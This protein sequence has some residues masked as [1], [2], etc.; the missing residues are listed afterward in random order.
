M[1]KKVIV[2]NFK[3]FGYQEFDLPSWVVISGPNNSGK[4]S[5]LQAIS[6]WCELALHWRTENPDLSRGDDGNYLSKEL[7]LLRFHSVLLEDFDHLWQYKNTR[8]PISIH[9]EISS[10][11]NRSIGFEI[12][13]S[14]REIAQVRPTKDANEDDL[15]A[16]GR[17]PMI[18]TYIPPVSGLERQ[19]DFYNN[20][21]VIL[22]R[23]AHA[24]GGTVLRNLISK[25]RED[26]NNWSLLKEEVYSHFGYEIMEPSSGAQVYIRYRHHDTDQQYDLSNAASGFLQILLVFAALLHRRASVVLLDEPDAHLHMLLQRKMYE[27]LKKIASK[28][29]SQLIIA[30]HSQE[31]I[32]VADTEELRVL[33]HEDGLRSIKEKHLRDILKFDNA[34]IIKAQTGKKVLYV[35]G[36]T[37]IGILIEWAKLLRHRMFRFL[38]QGLVLKTAEQKWT[39]IKHFQSL[40]SLV[41]SLL[42]A[43]LVD[44]DSQQ[45]HA[46]L[47]RT[48]DGL[49]R[50][51]WDR[52]ELENYLIHPDAICRY[53][54]TIAGDAVQRKI[55]DFLHEELPQ[56]LLAQPFKLGVPADP[57]GKAFLAQ[58]ME[59]AG[60]QRESSYTALAGM[61]KLNEIHPEV[62]EKLDAIADQL[63]I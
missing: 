1:I 33:T 11:S 32:N 15:E 14:Q 7:N 5:L 24:Q 26:E 27:S 10:L 2:K 63:D 22:Q 8:E 30:T 28:S 25:V 55:G 61:M 53:V 19:E 6:A 42:G 48:T 44:G 40:K 13:Y 18:A 47:L 3:N 54:K 50:M 46:E 36:Q 51:K 38:E 20:V 21:E 34:L 62:I 60:L 59:E 17:D 43:E 16:I 29:D 45:G 9:M 52:K 41:P 39:T 58:A 4:S 35:E 49:T 12:L 37:D 31:L 56:A 23:L 57:P